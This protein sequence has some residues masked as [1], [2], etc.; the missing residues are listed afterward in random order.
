MLVSI[1]AVKEK[2]HQHTL[3]QFI[4]NVYVGGFSA[5]L[6][7]CVCVYACAHYLFL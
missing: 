4:R 5:N 3:D 6:E 7:V 1:H 2:L